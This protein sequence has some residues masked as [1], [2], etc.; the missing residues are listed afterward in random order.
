MIRTMRF[1]L[2]MLAGAAIGYILGARAGRERYEQI[3]RGSAEL[4]KHP[5]VQQLASQATGVTDLAR[6]GVAGGLRIGS[7]KL[8]DAA[9]GTVT[10]QA[11]SDTG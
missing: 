2:G 7:E 1:R 10:V 6:S 11:S 4:R 5:A 9:D 3:K 8:R